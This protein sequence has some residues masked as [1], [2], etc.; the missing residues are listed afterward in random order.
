MEKYKIVFES[1]ALRDLREIVRY[2]AE[3]LKEPVIAERIHNSIKNQILSLEVMPYRHKLIDDE[4]LYK[5]EIR[6]I[7]VENY[8]VFYCVTEKSKTVH[9]FR[10]L[11]NRREWKNL[12]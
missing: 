9:I 11:Y 2:I 7:P 4:V 5:K 1:H 8:L 12:I 3:I 6:K 10:I